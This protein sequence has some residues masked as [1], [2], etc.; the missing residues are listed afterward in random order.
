MTDDF[1][2][3]A[4]GRIQYESRVQEIEKIKERNT[5]YLDYMKGRCE[6]V[7]PYLESQLLECRTERSRQKIRHRIKR[8]REIQGKLLGTKA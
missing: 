5:A 7:I 1:I 6:R 8:W 4:L 2:R 3:D